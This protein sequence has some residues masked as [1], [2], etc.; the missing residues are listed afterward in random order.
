MPSSKDESSHQCCRTLCHSLSCGGAELSKHSLWSLPG[1]EGGRREGGTRSKREGDEEE[2]KG[3]MSSV[4]VRLSVC[5]VR[6][7]CVCTLSVV[8]SVLCRQAQ[9]KGFMLLPLLS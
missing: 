8:S 5:W 7:V 4:C 3:A 9:K 6:C 2:G 1:R